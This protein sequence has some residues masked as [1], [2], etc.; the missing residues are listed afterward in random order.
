MRIVNFSE[1]DSFLGRILVLSTSKGVS[2]IT[3]DINEF[4]RGLT[5]LVVASFL[6]GGEAKR[7]TE[8]LSLYLQGKLKKF[9]INLDISSGTPFQ[10]S[11]WKE[12]LKIP[13]G[14]VKTY[15]EIARRIRN[16]CAARAVGNAAGANPIPIIIPCHRVV[17][18]NGIGGYSCGVEIKKKLLEIECKEVR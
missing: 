6:K 18:S 9:Q 17:A 15:G 3:F 2:Q 11:V 8:Q 16:P 4:E 1:L 13:Y 12:L 7:A 5:N 10:V 14:E